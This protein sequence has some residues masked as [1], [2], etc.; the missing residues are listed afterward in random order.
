MKFTA[1]T[2]M[3]IIRPGN[4]TI[5][6]WTS[7][8]FFASASMLPHVGVG[9]WTPN[10]RNDSEDS[11][12]MAAATAR[13]TRSE[14]RPPQMTRANSSRPRLS[15]PNQW[16]APGPWS[17]PIRSSFCGFC[18]GRIGAR[19]VTSVRIPS[20]NMLTMA[21]LWRLNRRH[22]ICRVERASI[23]PSYSTP[24]AASDG[25][26]STG[27]GSTVVGI[28]GSVSRIAN[29]RVQHRVRDVHDQVEDDHRRHHDH[30]PR[31]DLRI[32]PRRHGI[33]EEPAHPRPLEDVLR[34]DEAAGDGADVDAELRGDGDQRVAHAVTEDH[35]PLAEPLGPGRPH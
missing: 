32:V 2:V 24:S 3:R 18:S 14:M 25:S 22:A 1:S 5:G 11:A 6:G 10:P 27:M 16:W 12:R 4:H 13:V 26:I 33:D 31:Q 21:G 28:L 19:I 23:R 17:E 7:T 15:V 34:D 29:P 8:K 30:H 9:G 35:T 20:T